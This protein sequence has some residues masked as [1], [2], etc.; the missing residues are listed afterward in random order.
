MRSIR[1]DSVR[2]EWRVRPDKEGYRLGHL[3]E[4]TEEVRS[5]C[6]WVG[7]EGRGYERH[8][9]MMVKEDSL[10]EKKRCGLCLRYRDEWIARDAKQDAAEEADRKKFAEQ[11]EREGRF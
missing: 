11:D 1:Y 4:S 10:P 5:I 3:F 9:W 2:L 6:G 8:F 7:Q